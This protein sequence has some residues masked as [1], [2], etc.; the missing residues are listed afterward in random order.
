MDIC[1]AGVLDWKE[2]RNFL[3]TRMARALERARLNDS[4]CQ[5]GL[6]AGIVVLAYLLKYIHAVSANK[7][8]VAIHRDELLISV[9]L[10]MSNILISILRLPKP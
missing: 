10:A 3:R 7:T 6:A 2:R 4:P 8:T 5:H 9:F 1:Q